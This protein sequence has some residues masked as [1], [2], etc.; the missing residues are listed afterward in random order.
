MGIARRILA[1]LAI[2]AP[3]AIPVRAAVVPAVDAAPQAYFSV[4]DLINGS[5]ISHRQ[6]STIAMAVWATA[7][8]SSEC[9]RYFMSAQPGSGDAVV[10][11]HGDFVNAD[12]GGA[13]QVTAADYART[14]PREEM[15]DAAALARRFGRTAIVLARP[16]TF[17]S[18]GSELKVRH[19]AHEARL[20]DA[21]LTAIAG[22]Y[23]IGQFHLVGQ[24]GGAI[25]IGALLAMRTDIG[26]ASLGAGRLAVNAEI[27][28]RDLAHEAPETMLDD[29]SYVGGIRASPDLRLFVLSDPA[30]IRSSI[31]GQ[32]RFV[33]N[34]RAHGVPVTHLLTVANY[35]KE[36]HHDV[37]GQ[38]LRVL[39]ECIDGSSD[40]RIAAIVEQFAREN[41]RQWAAHAPAPRLGPAALRSSSASISAKIQRK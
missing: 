11:L 30:D 21:A 37:M 34:A 4:D 13:P 22:R 3:L 17:G 6:C 18:S 9:L 27:A 2:A 24:S 26:C 20:V 32:S 33:A 1:V 15:E 5:V 19:T 40:E 29:Q 25:L 38:A 23:G 12:N 8:G 10:L 31:V 16:G 36:A 28:D 14:G 35:D 7:D 39:Y 41:A